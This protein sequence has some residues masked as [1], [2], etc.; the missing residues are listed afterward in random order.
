MRISTNQFYQSGLSSILDQQSDLSK[1]QEQIA[2]GRKVMQPSDDPVAAISILNL[3][4]EIAL[5]ERY[6]TNGELGTANLSLEDTTL[7]SV[8]DIMQRVRELV[9]SG[10]NPTY[11][12]VER[13]TLSIELDGLLDQLVGLANFKNSSGDYMFAGHKIDDTPFTKNPAGG[14]QYNGDQGVRDIQI[15]TNTQLAMTD[16]GYQVFQNILNGNGDFVVGESSTNLGGGVIDSGSVN[17]RSAYISDGYTIDIV[18]LGAGTLGYNVT[19]SGGAPVVV[20]APYVPGADITFNGIQF[21]ITGTPVIG[22]SFSITPSNRQDLFTTLQNAVTALQT[23][24]TSIAERAH[25]D[26]ALSRVLV[27]IDQ[28]MEHIGVIHVDVGTRL[29]RLQNQNLVNNDFIITSKITLS[30]VKD[31]DMAEAITSLNLQKISLE[32]S[33]ATFVRIQNLSLFNFLR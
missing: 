2:T 24:G 32:A 4:R 27:D 22:D 26:N 19:D 21:N 11:G 7:Q 15:S 20:N 33:Q 16:S 17:D 1:I 6:I 25:R 30:N 18:D 9:L 23:T 10:G 29:N 12:D 28:S 31:L 8:T 14:F 3:E 13:N 5:T